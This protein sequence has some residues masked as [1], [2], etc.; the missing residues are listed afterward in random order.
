MLPDGN[1]SF[2][3]RHESSYPTNTEHDNEEEEN[4]NIE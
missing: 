1:K 4:D 2:L 3:K